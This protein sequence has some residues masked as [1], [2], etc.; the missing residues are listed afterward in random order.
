MGRSVVVMF[1]MFGM[2]SVLTD[3]LSVPTD[4][5]S[6]PTDEPSVPTDEPSVPTDEPS[7]PTDELRPGCSTGGCRPQGSRSRRETRQNGG[8]SSS[9]GRGE[10]A[11]FVSPGGR[12]VRGTPL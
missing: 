7:V 11:G 9:G 5:L 10:P 1:G 2:F 6:V 8:G 12:L 3:E 4:E